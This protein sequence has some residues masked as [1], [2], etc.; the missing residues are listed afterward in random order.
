MK[1][2][3]SI[4]N[5]WRDRNAYYIK[6]NINRPNDRYR[7]AY[8]TCFLSL[9]RNSLTRNKSKRNNYKKKP[10]CIYR[11][12]T[13]YGF[14]ICVHAL[15]KTATH[16][17]QMVEFYMPFVAFFPS[18]FSRLYMF[19]NSNS[20]RLNSIR[21]N[22]SRAHTI[23]KINCTCNGFIVSALWWIISVSLV[24]Y[25]FCMHCQK[26]KSEQFKLLFWCQE[27]KN[28]WN[29]LVFWQQP[30]YKHI[31]LVRKWRRISLCP[32][33]DKMINHLHYLPCYMT[34]F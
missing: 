21:Y 14:V 15:N 11:L 20:Q 28:Y 30:K 18:F 24:P 22:L 31:C 33:G 1:F 12:P 7:I 16:K 6:G 29:A 23:I 8:E 17:M 4:L 5:A 10:N 3:A 19:A 25:N 32:T 34:S 27:N 2:I 9:S 26:K 13:T